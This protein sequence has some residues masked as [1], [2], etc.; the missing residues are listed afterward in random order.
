MSHYE[1]VLANKEQTITELQTA[2][3]DQLQKLSTITDGRSQQW[4]QQRA[5]LEAHYTQLLTELHARHKVRVALGQ[6]AALG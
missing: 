1:A 2:H 3:E 6:G 4:S 5:D